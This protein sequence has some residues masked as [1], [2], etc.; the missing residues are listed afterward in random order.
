MANATSSTPDD[1]PSKRVR[2]SVV[3]SAMQRAS[4]SAST[5]ELYT[6]VLVQA[7]F[8]SDTFYCR[9]IIISDFFSHLSDVHVDGPC[10]HIHIGA[11]DILQQVFPAKDFVRILRK[12]KQKF[13][14]FF[15]QGYFPV[16]YPNRVASTV[17]GEIAG[18]D[19]IGGRILFGIPSE[20]RVDA[21]HQGPWFYGFSDIIV[22]PH[23][24]CRNFRILLRPRC[25]EYDES[26]LQRSEEH[27][28][29]LQSRENLVC[30]LL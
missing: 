7:E 21:A 16:V 18:G 13:E 11:P 20:K 12:K 15:R 3:I 17:D 29:E 1:T 30:R 6:I 27:T 23:V 14:F 10:E 5:R 19:D 25:K 2:K 9:N 26:L 4:K 8:I 24:K 22:S 28:S